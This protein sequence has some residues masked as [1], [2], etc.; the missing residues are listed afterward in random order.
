MSLTL[1][2]QT[3]A[4]LYAIFRFEEQEV[5]DEDDQELDE[6]EEDDDY[7]RPDVLQDI[8]LHALLPTPADP[9]FFMVKCGVGTETDCVVQLMR[10]ALERAAAGEPLLI[11]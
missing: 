9:F 5:S 2:H 3:M 6:E 10:R 4:S 1:L 11:R 8:D 7:I